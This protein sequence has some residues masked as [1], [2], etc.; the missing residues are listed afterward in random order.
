MTVFWIDVSGA[1]VRA[2][3]DDGAKPAGA[4]QGIYDGAGELPKDTIAGP[5]PVSRLSKW[6]G[7]AWTAPPAPDPLADYGARD[8]AK[9]LVDKGVLV[10]ADLDTARGS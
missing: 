4:V 10:K 3:S 5:S 8:V 9:A 7:D 6:T 1:V 2:T